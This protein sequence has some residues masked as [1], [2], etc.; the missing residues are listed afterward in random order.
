M[1]LVF[2][3]VCNLCNGFVRFL[4]ERDG[5][6]RL[7]FTT[8]Q[9]AAGAEIMRA[10]EID[11]LD[12]ASV[13][14]VDDDRRYVYSDASLLALAALGGGWRLVLLARLIPKFLRDP[15]YR[16]VARRRYRWFGRSDS[17]RTPDPRWEDRFLA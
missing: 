15:A 7:Q 12:P 3:G 2:D 6:G 1:L 11:P 17:C 8:C 16:F 14:L 5:A 4:L 13:V 10:A 9:S